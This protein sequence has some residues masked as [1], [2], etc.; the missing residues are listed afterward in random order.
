MKIIIVKILIR[1]GTEPCKIALWK[2]WTEFHA[3]TYCYYYCVLHDD[4]FMVLDG[5]WQVGMKYKMFKCV[6]VYALYPCVYRYYYHTIYYYYY[7]YLATN[8]QR[9]RLRCYCLNVICIPRIHYIISFETI[10]TRTW[11]LWPCSFRL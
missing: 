10:T 1:L 9:R 11:I 8:S 2:L 5:E 4:V 3:T 7:N 6:N